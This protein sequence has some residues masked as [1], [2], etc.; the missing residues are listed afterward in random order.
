MGILLFGKNIVN[1]NKF[2]NIGI[3]KQAPLKL[4]LKKGKYKESHFESFVNSK[5]F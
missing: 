1:F 4:R 3:I 2:F 5:I